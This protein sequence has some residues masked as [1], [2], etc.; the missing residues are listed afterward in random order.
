MANRQFTQFYY[1]LRKMC[2]Q[3]DSILT[4]G[5][6]GSVASFTGAGI[7][8]MT[9]LSQGVYRAQLQDNY[10]GGLAYNWEAISGPTGA[11]IAGGSFV[12]GTLYKIASPGNTTTAQWVTAGLPAGLTPA[13]GQAFVALGA[14]AGTGTVQAVGNGGISAVEVVSENMLN[15]VGLNKGLGGYIVFKTMSSA[16]ALVDPVNGAKLSMTF[17]LSNSTAN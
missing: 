9:R 3:I 10:V 5:A 12:A 4:F 2:V 17:I 14:G 13:I 15:P 8:N 7:A 1:T 16:F 11:A 6:T